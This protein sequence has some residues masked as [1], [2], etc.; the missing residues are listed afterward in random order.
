MVAVLLDSGVDG[1]WATRQ[2]ADAHISAPVLMPFEVSNIIRRSERAGLI[3][4]DAAAQAHADCLH[5]AMDLWPY[6]SLAS[7]AWE[8]RHNLTVYDASY[9]ALAEL[10]GVPLVTLDQAIGKTPGLRCE[11]LVP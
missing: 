5:R 6:D 1:E 8:L 10:L 9:V 11:V 3:S 4:S 2:L 7:R